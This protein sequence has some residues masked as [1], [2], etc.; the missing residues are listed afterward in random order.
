MAHPQLL[1]VDLDLYDESG[2]DSLVQ[3]LEPQTFVLY[4][5]DK[6]AISSS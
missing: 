4:K 2:V 3:A 6:F 5:E 1:N